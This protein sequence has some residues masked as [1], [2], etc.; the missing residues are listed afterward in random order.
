MKLRS[1][2][3]CIQCIARMF[4]CRKSYAIQKIEQEEETVI[5]TR[6]SMMQTTFDDASTYAGGTVFS[7]D[8]G[9]LEEV[10]TYVC[11]LDSLELIDGH[12]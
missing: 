1:A 6:M 3:V 9:L 12:D 11:I 8:E 10:E 7:V 2:A 5:D 4:I